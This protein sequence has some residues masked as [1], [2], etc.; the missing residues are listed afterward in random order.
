M[1]NK[2]QHT[3]EPWE[4]GA[5]KR[6]VVYANGQLS[7]VI[8]RM[9][10]NGFGNGNYND[11]EPE[12]NA[13]RIVVCVNALSGLTND[14]INNLPKVIDEGTVAIKQRDELLNVL[15]FVYKQFSR[16]ESA[17]GTNDCEAAFRMKGIIESYKPKTNESTN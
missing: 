7:K 8:A 3:P 6:S 13:A 1:S 15:E 9:N 12:S 17:H 14:E 4:V 2:T 10:F 5:S 11:D 16:F